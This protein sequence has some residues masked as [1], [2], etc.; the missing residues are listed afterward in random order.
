[1][2]RWLDHGLGESWLETPEAAKLLVGSFQYFDGERYLLDE[3]AVMPNHA[4]AL[5]YPLVDHELSD[6]AKGW[7]GYSARE[8]KKL[9]GRRG[10]FWQ[11]EPFDHIVRDAG[12]LQRFRDYIRGNP[13]KLPGRYAVGG[14]GKFAEVTGM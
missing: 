13:L 9:L 7:K 3:Y 5:V 12:S 6:I 1:M 11:H 8:I 10:Q 14:H 4:H 2:Q